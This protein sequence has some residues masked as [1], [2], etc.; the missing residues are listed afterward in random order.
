MLLVKG[1]FPEKNKVNL[2]I[3]CNKHHFQPSMLTLSSYYLGELDLDYHRYGSRN[4]NVSKQQIDENCR[5]KI[6]WGRGVNRYILSSGNHLRNAVKI[7]WVLR[8]QM[9]L[10]SWQPC[11]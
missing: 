1:L 11:L 5:Y 10:V 3:Y 6:A 7:T 4:V 2:Q 8:Y 9:T